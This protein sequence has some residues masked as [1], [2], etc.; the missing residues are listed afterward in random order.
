MRFPIDVLFLDR[1]G[2]I[3]HGGTL[4]PWKLSPWVRRSTGVLEL[5]AGTL[6]RTGTEAGDRISLKG[7]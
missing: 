2:L 6:Q 4:P 3:L 5:P 1:E 7:P